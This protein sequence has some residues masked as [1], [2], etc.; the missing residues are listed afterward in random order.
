MIYIWKYQD[1]EIVIEKPHKVL[2]ESLLAAL[3]IL[4]KKRQ[5]DKNWKLKDKKGFNRQKDQQKE[6]RNKRTVWYCDVRV[7]SHS[8]DVF[9]VFEIIT[10]L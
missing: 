4:E 7:V 2:K 8:C 5:K 3:A 1:T 6:E 9:D 10:R